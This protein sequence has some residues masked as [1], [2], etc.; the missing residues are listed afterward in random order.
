MSSNNSVPEKTAKMLDI[1]AYIYLFM[2]PF[3]I[4]HI[5]FMTGNR[6][7]VFIGACIVFILLGFF[8]MRFRANQLRQESKK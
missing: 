1:A 3:S 6:N 7:G 8:S 2:G 5:Y 4:L